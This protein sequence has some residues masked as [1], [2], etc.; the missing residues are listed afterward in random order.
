MEVLILSIIG[1]SWILAAFMDA[2]AFGHPSRNL[3][4]LWHIAKALS[5]GLPYFYLIFLV[6]DD[7]LV[8]IVFWGFCFPSLYFIQE[9]FYPLFRSLSVW[10]MDRK[11][12]IP[13]LR[14]LW[15]IS[16]EDR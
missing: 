12:E 10:K 7:W 3:H 15:S 1:F 9:I 14:K 2:I 13:W 6:T 5:H 4:E 11:L 8:R 16:N